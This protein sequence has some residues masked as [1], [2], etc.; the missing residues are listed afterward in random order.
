MSTQ[1]F[2]IWFLV[3]CKYY[4]V[5]K[6]IVQYTNFTNLFSSTCDYGDK[7]SVNS[8]VKHCR[9]IL[10]RR[11]PSSSSALRLHMTLV[12][13]DLA[14]CSGTLVLLSIVITAA[15]HPRLEQCFRNERDHNSTNKKKTNLC[16]RHELAWTVTQTMP[17]GVLTCAHKYGLLI[18]LQL[19]VHLHAWYTLASFVDFGCFTLYSISVILSVSVSDFGLVIS[20]DFCKSLLI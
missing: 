10:D 3:T 8:L 20:V 9:V 13:C 18:A 5:G 16:T 6:Y 19:T 15:G 1:N 11:D 2:K 17:N 4:S 12:T 14:V 7:L